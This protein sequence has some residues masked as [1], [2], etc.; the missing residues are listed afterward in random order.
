MIC[1][2]WKVVRIED[3]R[4][5]SSVIGWDSGEVLYRKG[6]WTLPLN[7]FGPLCVFDFNAKGEA[8]DFPPARSDYSLVFLCEY[9]PSSEKAVW[10]LYYR[11]ALMSLPVGTRLATRVRLLEK[12]TK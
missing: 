7:G 9:E 6:E 12:E 8:F 2:G 4:F 10:T 1:R 11:Q 5:M 3:Q